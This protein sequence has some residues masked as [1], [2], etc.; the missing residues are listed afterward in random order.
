LQPAAKGKQP[1]SLRAAKKRSGP[2]LPP[3]QVWIA[4][5]G[6]MSV[7][8]VGTRHGGTT[9]KT[10]DQCG[11]AGCDQ[12]GTPSAEQDAMTTHLL[13]PGARSHAARAV[14]GR[15]HKVLP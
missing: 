12:A 11:D 3:P 14:L 8:P 1:G 2:L 4:P 13:L 7:P 5:A 9:L 6:D 15:G 10:A